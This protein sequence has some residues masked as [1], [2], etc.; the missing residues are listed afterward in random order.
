MILR[1]LFLL[2]LAYAVPASAQTVRGTVVERE[3]QRPIAGAFV[4]LLDAAGDGVRADITG[5]G[6]EFEHHAPAPGWYRLRVERIGVQTVTSEPLEIGAGAVLEVPMR[7]ETRPVQLAPIAADAGSRCTVRPSGGAALEQAWDEARKALALAAWTQ[8]Q[9]GVP[10]TT[11]TYERTRALGSLDVHEEERRMRSGFDR[12]TFFSASARELA[13]DGYVRAER[14]GGFTYYGLDAGNLLSDDFLDT[15]CFRLRA[16]PEDD[17]ALLG[18][19]FEPVLGRSTPDIR[20]VLWLDRASSELRHLEFRYTRHLRRQPV[21]LEYFGGRVDFTRLE[22]GAWIVERWWIR[23]P[24]M[25]RGAP[26]NVPLRGELVHLGDLA[27]LRGLELEIAAQ[28]LGMTIREAGG[29]VV[30][31]HDVDRIGPARQ[32]TAALEGVVVD[33]VRGA[34]LAGAVVYVAGTHHAAR[35]DGAGRFRLAG[36]PDGEQRVSFF[37][38]RTDSLLL[39]MPMRPVALASGGTAAVTLALPRGGECPG[40]A[41]LQYAA[42]LGQ[43]R[44]SGRDVA[45][46]DAA[47]WAGFAD[48]DVRPPRGTPRK[49]VETRSDSSGR[50]LLCGLPLNVKLNVRAAALALGVEG[51]QRTFR[52]EGLYRHDFLLSEPETLPSTP[53]EP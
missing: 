53:A 51:I 42:L 16:E 31:V 4:V 24:Q 44:D 48:P 20:G 36:L 40:S 27:R 7:V 21:P 47:V 14:D 11:M 17:P 5:P 19:E 49:P 34:P 39:V 3:S 2:L 38:P 26:R 46:R 18:L 23:M 35:T 52:E 15:H 32:G 41:L 12:A 25:R 22:N 29:E 30:L 1:I 10:F 13:S 33:S 8:E 28:R 43:V 6:G 50:Y 37:H 45:V 9:G